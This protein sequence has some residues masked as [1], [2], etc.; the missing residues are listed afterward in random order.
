MDAQQLHNILL[1][2]FSTDNAA[3]QAAE[4]QIANLHNVRGSLLLL[5]QITVE[6][7]VAR[8]IRQAA[9]VSLK[10]LV[11][12]YWE[13]DHVNGEFVRVIPEDERAVSRQNALEALFV[14]HDN[15]LRSLLAET[16]SYIARI[17]FPE[18][19]PNLIE[20]IV[21][22]I[23]SGD[24]KRIIN[25]LLALRRVVKNFE[26]RADERMAP[27]H[28]LAEKI[29]PML[30][31]MFAQLL[32]NNSLEAAMMMHL[33]LKT[34][35]SCVKAH[36]TP[37]LATVENVLAWNELFRAVIAKPL[38]EAHE[39]AE[40]A[41]QPTDEEE[42]ENWPWWKIKKWSLQ[43]ICR[44]YTRYGNP[45]R[46]E[47]EYSAMSEVYRSQ[48]APGLLACIL[49]ALSLRKNGR[50]C[51][52]RVVQ[53]SLVFLQEAVDSSVTYKLIKPHLPFLLFEVIHPVLCLTPKDLKLWAEDPHEFVRKT[54][55]VFEDFLNPVYAAANLLADLCTKRGKDCLSNV[56]M[57]Y[58]NVLTTYLSQPESERDYI[59]KD[60]ALHAL[61]SL[62]GVL[63]KSKAH[64]AQVETMIT[65]HILPEF[66]NPHGF[67]RLRA[68]KLFSRKYIE[69]IRFRDEQ[70]LVQIVNGMLDCMFDP[71]LPVRIEAA[72]TIRFVVQYPHS[73]TVLE[74][75]QP[76]LPQILE[77]FF[78]LM[79]EI[80]NDEVVIA[81]EQIIDKFADQI[82]PFSLQLIAKFVEFFQQF[83]VAGEED[84]DAC[85]AAVSCLDAINTILVS[86]H[87]H[88]E[89][90]PLMVPSL[91]PILEKV[92]TDFDYVEYMESGLE[93][94]G[95]LAYCCNKIPPQLWALF[96][97]IFTCF[98]DFAADYLP[99]F[100]HVIDNFVGRDIDT[101]VAG[102]YTDKSGVQ[103]RYVD[104]VVGMAQRVLEDKAAQE[105][106]ICAATRLLY[107]LLH[108]LF[109]KV[110]DLVYEMVRLGASRLASDEMGDGAVRTLLG[111]IASLLHYNPLLTVEALEHLQATQGVF[112]LW[113]SKLSLLESPL[114][115]KL[116]V[117]G[118]MSLLK[119]PVDKVPAVLRPHM[120]HVIQ[121]A[122]KVL[123]EAIQNPEAGIHDDEDEE[124]GDEQLE[125][126]L[127]AGGYSSDQ[128]AEDVYDDDYMAILK[129]LREEA[130]YD[131]MYDDD[132]DED[133]VSLLDEI[134]EVE[135]FLGTLQAFAQ[136]NAA[137]YQSLQLEADPQAQQLLAFF[138]EEHTRRQERK[139]QRAQ[140]QA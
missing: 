45:K 38:P 123:G 20:V 74:V 89:L 134:D 33:I 121:E 81:L 79:D 80:G 47:D 83:T 55:D 4:A 100:V 21:Q 125:Q 13:G 138:S 104:L 37:H 127:D 133:Y 39:G 71:E 99:N 132:G 34:Y 116:F 84:E 75:L 9:A 59:Q 112:T 24:A 77:Q 27:L 1:H 101:F 17:D 50:F 72:K 91:A 115:R 49:E 6:E 16:V 139:A 130:N 64:K 28:V 117:L 135:F 22:N 40:P 30:R 53:L 82:G 31:E 63:T 11:N 18:N 95:S 44:F 54:N 137:D 29:F 67:L 61:F 51:S 58:T 128:D 36:L 15:S 5:I 8:E 131:G 60:A 136:T 140:E 14:T 88:P 68:C 118:V 129:Q 122:M 35:W 41:G 70:T 52:D 106:D 124:E 23:Q 110:D 107:S 32:T 126:L 26:Y 97:L 93:I 87:N 57:F 92:L 46:V 25:A 66:K 86:V 69:A 111:L 2:T 48:V 109:G 120:K 42:R 3:R 102:V 10:N 105:V 56:L 119:L 65:T 98:D 78:N 7:S 108:N 19:W 43:I 94:F 114:D 90:Y 12:R 73:D 96:P 62:D 76:R 113:M 85:L 103:K